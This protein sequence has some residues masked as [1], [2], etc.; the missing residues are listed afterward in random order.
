MNFAILKGHI[1]QE[2]IIRTLENGRK[3][4]TFTIATTARYKAEDGSWKEESPVWH[5][6]VAWGWLADIPVEKG[7]LVEVKGKINNRSYEKDGHTHYRSE[8]VATEIDIIKKFTKVDAAVLPTA[9]DD[10]LHKRRAVDPDGFS[11]PKTSVHP[12]TEIIDDL[13]F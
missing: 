3:V 1:G 8:V 10:P 6:I 2:P 4:S 7:N 11:I 13:P 5:N 9:T 12:P